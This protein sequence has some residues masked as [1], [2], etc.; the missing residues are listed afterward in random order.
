MEE[1]P[2]GEKLERLEKKIDELAWLRINKVDMTPFLGLIVFYAAVRGC[3]NAGEARDYAQ[4]NRYEWKAKETLDKLDKVER[5]VDELLEKNVT[6][7][8]KYR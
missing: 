4:N 5:K 7:P 8:E 1:E 2:L 3:Y 6:L